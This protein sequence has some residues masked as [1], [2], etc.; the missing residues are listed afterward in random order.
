MSTTKTSIPKT[1]KKAISTAAW[2]DKLGVAYDTE[3]KTTEDE[4]TVI[5]TAKRSGRH[6]SWDHSFVAFYYTRSS[7]AKRVLGGNRRT[8]EKVFCYQYDGNGK[9]GKIKSRDA[10]LTVRVRYGRDND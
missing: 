10:H 9:H 6:A 4:A 1:H 2:L 7:W 8:C 3:V 5:L